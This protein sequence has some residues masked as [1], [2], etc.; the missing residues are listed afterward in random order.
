M[1]ATPTRLYA[2]RLAPGAAPTF[3]R[4]ANST[5]TSSTATNQSFALPSYSVGDVV[6]FNVV[7]NGT[8]STFITTSNNP[9]WSIISGASTGGGMVM[10]KLMSDT[11]QTSVNSTYPAGY[12][13]T[14]GAAV[15]SGAD[16]VT[17]LGN[18]AASNSPYTLPAPSNVTATS[19][20]VAMVNY[21]SSYNF[22]F[23]TL[24]SR[25]AQ[26][27]PY[28]EAI[29]DLTI[30]VGYS[31]SPGTVS[32]PGAHNNPVF[33]LSRQVSPI[34][35]LYT[36]T[37]KTVITSIV[38][39]GGP[40]A[41]GTPGIR[42]AGYDV[43][44]GTSTGQGSTLKLSPGIVIESGETIQGFFDAGYPSGITQG[45]DIIISGVVMS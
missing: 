7:S 27:N 12:S 6:L 38:I 37:A 39:A 42:V 23:S 19:I 30:P 10:W 13:V 35:T 26:S 43:V 4:A 11:S 22:S 34:S 1:T 3:T 17:L 14:S 44:R 24:T 36:A 45:P 8:P 41:G 33:L 9:G 2:G 5:A 15:Y 31:S 18:Y 25:Q 32:G 28:G 40:T 21:L 16:T 20:Y 29:G